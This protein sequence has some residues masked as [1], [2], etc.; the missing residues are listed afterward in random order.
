MAIVAGTAAWFAPAVIRSLPEPEADPEL[1]GEAPVEGKAV[2]APSVPIKRPYVELA[3]RGGLSGR[4]AIVAAL[5]AG[6]IGLSLG[7]D[8]SL[9][10]WCFLSV[11]G[12]VL[13]YLD[14]TTHLLPF[15]LVAPAY[16]ITIVLILLA[17]VISGDGDSLLR[18]GIAWIVVYAIFALMWVVY[19]RGIG[20]GDVRLSGILAMSLGWLGWSY[21]VVGLYTAFVVGA[22][23][24][25]ILALAKVVD[26]K[27]Y[28]FGPFL[29]FGTWLGVIVGSGA[30]AWMA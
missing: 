23:V 8:P 18:S 5:A 4:L 12:V 24:G 17:A 21:V 11:L 3:A 2:V 15:R 10:V 13:S 19:R 7:P 25:G 26:R 22:V 1:E 29:L 30:S 9:P 14:L 20:Y 27:G 16:P 28:A 6:S